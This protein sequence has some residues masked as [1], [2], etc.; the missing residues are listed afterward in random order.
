MAHISPIPFEVVVDMK[1]RTLIEEYKKAYAAG[2]IAFFFGVDKTD[3]GLC[4]T[5]NYRV[6][7]IYLCSDVAQF[8]SAYD[9]FTSWVGIMTPHAT[10]AGKII[11]K[12]YDGPVVVYIE[13]LQYKQFCEEAEH[14]A[15]LYCRNNIVFREIP[16]VWF[17]DLQLIQFLRN[18]LKPHPLM[19]AW[20]SRSDISG[21]PMRLGGRRIR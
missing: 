4:L 7:G 6:Q 14:V 11:G 20:F 21:T 18:H 17:H 2:G 1:P 10:Q 3:L 13:P 9:D 16:D 19:V 15:D 12:A 8:A 5:I